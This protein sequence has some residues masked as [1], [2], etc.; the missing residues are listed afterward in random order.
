MVKVSDSSWGRNN[1][2]T[3]LSVRLRNPEYAL[4]TERVR[5]PEYKWF[6]VDLVNGS[7]VDLERM[8]ARLT[9]EVVVLQ[10]ERE[11]GSITDE[12]AKHL[13]RVVYYRATIKR[14]VINRRKGIGRAESLFYKEFFDKARDIMSEE[15]FAETLSLIPKEVKK[16][17]ILCPPRRK[18]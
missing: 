4:S 17:A 10:N 18:R 16:A 6:V 2:E 13:E 12:A 7:T 15:A 8:M 1:S 3:C 14:E 9:E 5:Y 11:S